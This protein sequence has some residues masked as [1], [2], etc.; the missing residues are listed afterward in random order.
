MRDYTVKAPGDT[1]SSE[2]FNE[3]IGGELENFITKAGITLAALTTNQMSQAAS[4]YTGTAT[5]FIDSGSAD[6]YV[7]AIVA[8]FEAPPI[9][10][11]GYLMRVFP[12]NTNT[13]AST[14]NV[15]GTGAKDIV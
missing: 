10:P 1:F 12:G 8:P 9:L 2:Q 4:L 5:Y 14:I 15:A 13:G 11:D 3:S 7:A 6:A